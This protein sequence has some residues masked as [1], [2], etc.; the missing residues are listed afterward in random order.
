MS[1]PYRFTSEV[2]EKYVHAIV[3]GMHNPENVL[4]FFTEAHQA[5]VDNGKTSVLIEMRLEGPT[6]GLGHIFSVIQQRSG[7]AK[8]LRRIAYVD[9]GRE[10]EKAEFAE[11]VARNRGVNVRLFPNVADAKKWLER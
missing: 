8:E 1:K 5:C 4:R 6:M 9:I 11:N 2:H 3:T 7:P 10:L